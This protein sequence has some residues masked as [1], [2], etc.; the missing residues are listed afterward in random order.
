MPTLGEI[1]GREQFLEEEYNRDN[2]KRWPWGSFAFAAIVSA[3]IFLLAASPSN[4]AEFEPQQIALSVIF[5]LIAVILLVPSVIG[6][7]VYVIYKCVRAI[8]WKCVCQ[9]CMDKFSFKK[10]MEKVHANDAKMAPPPSYLE[11]ERAQG[12]P[13]KQRSVRHPTIGNH[14]ADI[15]KERNQARY[16]DCHVFVMQ[17]TLSNVPSI[18][19]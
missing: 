5:I 10:Q 12:K 6:I 1:Q 15:S 18:L 9:D 17:N 3:A 19:S 16:S 13:Y 14:M 4:M 2:Y 8:G 11:S 7:I